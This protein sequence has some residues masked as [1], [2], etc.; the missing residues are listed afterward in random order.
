MAAAIK[1]NSLEA[2]AW[3]EEADAVTCN[4][5]PAVKVAA[6]PRILDVEVASNSSV[7]PSRAT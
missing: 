3:L 6:F 5:V 1:P 2:M 7:V 4:S